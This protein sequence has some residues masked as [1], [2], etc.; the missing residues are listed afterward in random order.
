M[1]YDERRVGSPPTARIEERISWSG[2][3]EI[4]LEGEFDLTL[5][6]RLDP[7]LERAVAATGDVLLNL[8]RCSLIDACVLASIVDA[9]A[10]IADRGGQL[11][12]YG[13]RGQVRRV[14]EVTERLPSVPV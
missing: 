1:F 4:R 11:H 13:P 14:L 10:R 12:I 8:E 9:E 2:C 6:E 7:S 3:T 5:A